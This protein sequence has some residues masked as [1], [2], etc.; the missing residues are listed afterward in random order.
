M[1]ELGSAEAGAAHTVTETTVA[2]ADAPM[3]RLRA[4]LTGNFI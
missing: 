1:P 4:R 2:A 3:R